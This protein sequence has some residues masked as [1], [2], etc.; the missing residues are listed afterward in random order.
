MELILF[1]HT[2]V[3]VE[4]GICYG[5]LDLELANGEFQKASEALKSLGEFDLVVSSPLKRC[6]GPALEVFPNCILEQGIQEIHFG[7]WEGLSWDKVSR[8]A[9]DHWANDTMDFKPPNGESF[10]DLIKRVDT[11]L[12]SLKGNRVL[13]ITHAG[14]LKCL[15]LKTKNLSANNASSLKFHYGESRSYSFSP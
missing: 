6:A 7:D 5:Q 11:V 1:R 8:E 14:V 2:K 13:W 9:L 3:Q 12:E 15:E 4:Q 10:R